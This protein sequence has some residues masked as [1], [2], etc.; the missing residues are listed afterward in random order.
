[1]KSRRRTQRRLLLAVV[2]V[3]AVAL[4]LALRG[5]GALDGLERSSV[6]ARFMVRGQRPP[7]KDIVIVALDG[8]SVRDLGLRPPIAPRP[9]HTQLLRR[10]AAAKPRLVAYDFQFF[11][12]STPARD[13]PLAAAV[14]S[15]RPVVLATHDVDGPPLPVLANHRDVAGLGATAGTVG[16][17]AD[18]DGSIRRV[19]YAGSQWLGFAVVA[20][21]AIRGQAED[22]ADYPAWIDYRGPAGTYP[23]YSFSR[24]LRGEVP[25]AAFRGKI[26]LVGVTDPV[27]KDVFDTP[28]SD[29]PMPGIEIHANAIDTILARFPLVSAPAAVDVALVVLLAALVPLALLALSAPKA[30]LVAALGLVALL[31]G[32]QI[33]FDH[34]SVVAFIYPALALVVGSAGGLGTQ[35]VTETRERM[36]MRRAFARFVP[37]R[38]IDDVMQRTDDD[39]RLG[40]ATVEATVMFCDLRGFTAFAERNSAATVIDTLNRYLTEMSEAILDHGGTVVSYMGDGIMAVFGAPVEQHDHADQAV[41]AAIEMLDSRLPAFNA[42]VEGQDLGQGFRIGIGIATGPVRSGNV[43]S[44]RRLE[45]AAVGDTT[46]VAARLQAQSKQTPH[47]VLVDDAT[48]QQLGDAVP[49]LAAAG[50]YMLTGRTSTTVV[51]TLDREDEAAPA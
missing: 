12:A 19:P 44:Q 1:M 16:L 33:A 7:R 25:P 11:N 22:R 42:W 32:D 2:A 34:G 6:D 23:A 51:W 37:E 27:Y 8:A 4:T 29:Q 5:V 43:G 28:F 24:V 35:F 13:R 47:Q 31:V 36:R 41:S 40:S 48:R 3:A 14:S 46:N 9:I 45:Y 18:P 10:L 20:A 38:V 17:P 21:E 50:Q 15:A 39:F 49:A 30:M 26:V